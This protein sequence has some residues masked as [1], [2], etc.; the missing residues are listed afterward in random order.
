MTAPAHPS[1]IVVPCI[2]PCFPLKQSVASTPRLFLCGSTELG[3]YGSY[4]SY[5]DHVC[6]YSFLESIK[7][8]RQFLV[9]NCEDNSDPARFW[10][11]AFTSRNQVNSML[12]ERRQMFKYHTIFSMNAKHSRLQIVFEPGFIRLDTSIL[13]N[14]PMSCRTQ[15]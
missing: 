4:G 15:G 1:A 6:F 7:K 13:G 2:R 12:Q 11:V 14:G 10:T 3:S 5:G 8:L 9:G